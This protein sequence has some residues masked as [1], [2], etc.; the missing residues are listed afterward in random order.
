[1][2]SVHPKKVAAAIAAVLQ[3]VAETEAA[4]ACASPLPP[5][6]AAG[7][8]VGLPPLWAWSGRQDAMHDRVALQRR[9]SKSW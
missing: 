1:M 8:P 3:H 5:R 6:A 4:F 9:V 7:P 2:G